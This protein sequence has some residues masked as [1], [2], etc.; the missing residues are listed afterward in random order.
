MQKFPFPGFCLMPGNWKKKTFVPVDH[1]PDFNL[2]SATISI[3]NTFPMKNLTDFRKTVETGLDP[4][5]R[6]MRDSTFE[7]GAGQLRSVTK[8]APPQPFL[9]VKRCP[10][11][12]DFRGGPKATRYGVN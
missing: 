1:F 10:I 11:R 3:K 9:C 4:R 8:I 12:Y 7:I 6:S 2:E 5:L